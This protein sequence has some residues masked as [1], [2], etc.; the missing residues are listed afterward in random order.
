MRLWVLGARG[1]LGTDLRHSWKSDEVIPAEF[2]DADIQEIEQ[3]RTLV[4]RT[5]PDWVVL[6]P[7]YTDVDGSES[8]PNLAFAVNAR[9]SEDLVRVAK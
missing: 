8:N 7:T 9:G 2:A 4:S 5:Q 6:S 3:V 1:M